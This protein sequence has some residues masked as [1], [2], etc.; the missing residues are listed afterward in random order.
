MTWLKRAALALGMVSVFAAASGLAQSAQPRTDKEQAQATA[1]LGTTAQSAAS[2][3]TTPQPARPASNSSAPVA[4]NAPFAPPSGMP[5]GSN[6][7]LLGKAKTVPGGPPRMIPDPKVG[8]PQPGEWRLQ[9]VA[10]PIGREG[11]F[12]ND[13]VLEPV[14]T[15]VTV[16][17]FLLIGYCIV[18][19]RA[20]PGREP[21]KLAHNTT[22]EIIWTVAPVLILL[23][24][25]VPSFQLLAN[26]YN[27]PKADLTI[28]ATGHQ[29]YWEYSYPDNGGFSYDS[30]MLSE[31][32]S[33]ANGN[34]RLLDVDNR[35]VV[36]VGATVK[37]LTT[38]ADVIHAFA[39]PSLWVQMDAVPGRI[40]ETWFKVDKPGVYYGQCFQICGVRHGFMPIAIEVRPRAEF[41]AWIA[42]KQKEN[43]IASAAAKGSAVAEAN[44]APVAAPVKPAA[45]T[46]TDAPTGADKTPVRPS[47]KTAT[48]GKGAVNNEGGSGDA[49]A[50]NT[51]I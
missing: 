31:K 40:N 13:K 1:P 17:V 36:P 35:L 24:I 26:Q 28:K 51:K 2:V 27:P 15:A 9:N 14:L 10:T 4:S 50:G 21:S 29:W 18:A 33:A 34:P 11:K 5:G 41:N 23:G 3:A 19:F 39:V 7:P 32:E 30:V 38:A 37:V 25:A 48:P 49:S 12:M 42:A 45:L 47:G 16:F 6:S 46:P 20:R 8:M 44:A 43:G 22:I